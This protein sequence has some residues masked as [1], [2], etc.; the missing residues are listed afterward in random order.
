L[1]EQVA[2]KKVAGYQEGMLEVCVTNMILVP[3]EK[4]KTSEVEG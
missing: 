1:K 4:K 2:Q 3:R